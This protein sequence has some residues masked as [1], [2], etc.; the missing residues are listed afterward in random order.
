MPAPLAP[1]NFDAFINGGDD[2][3]GVLTDLDIITPRVLDT[4]IDELDRLNRPGAMNLI[5]NA[6]DAVSKA[7]RAA[8]KVRGTAP[9]NQWEATHVPEADFFPWGINHQ[10]IVGNDGE[11][12]RESYEQVF[13]GIAVPDSVGNPYL[14]VQMSTRTNVDGT[15]YIAQVGRFKS[16]SNSFGLRFEQRPGETMT[17]VTLGSHEGPFAIS[18]TG[19]V[20]WELHPL[21]RQSKGAH[22]QVRQQTPEHWAHFK[23]GTQGGMRTTNLA[24]DRTGKLKPDGLTEEVS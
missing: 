24:F 22:P 5:I 6:R 4:I 16:C 17:R 2:L 10:G 9:D 20:G 3:D 18:P 1:D 23:E 14:G 12:N 13:R 11:G 21:K 8:A 19:H 7:L 15:N